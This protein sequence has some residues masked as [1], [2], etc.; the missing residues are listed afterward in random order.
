MG[1]IRFGALGL[2]LLLA[3]PLQLWAVETE[4]GA[5]TAED[6]GIS[7]EEYQMV[8]EKGMSRGTLMHLLEVG[9]SPNEYFSEPWKKLG[10]TEEHW[11]SEKK[12]GMEDDDINRNFRKQQTNN[13]APFI[14]FVLPGYYHYHTRR[15]YWG[16]GLSTAAAGSLALTFLDKDR[17]A[18]GSFSVRPIYP[19]CLL[20]TMIWSAGDAFV[21][22]RFIDNQEATRFSFDATP[23]PDGAALRLALRF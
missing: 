21:H 20:V 17:E 13:L 8:R 12:A 5:T 19:I 18:K 23:L 15:L 2:G 3:L 7:A 22:T 16:L 14:A 11:L 9:V 6:L 4:W 10:V 1:R